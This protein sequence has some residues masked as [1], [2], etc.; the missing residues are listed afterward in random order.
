[1]DIEVAPE[2][3]SW[4][5]VFTPIHQFPIASLYQ[6]QIAL[7]NSFS[8]QPHLPHPNVLLTLI[9]HTILLSNPQ[10]YQVQP[11]AALQFNFDLKFEVIY[12]SEAHG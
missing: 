2:N 7:E 3:P 12:Q 6:Q 8:T 4:Q 11:F 5:T 1:M 10:Q 9:D